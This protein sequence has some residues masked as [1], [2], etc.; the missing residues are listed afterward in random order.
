M[1]QD[2]MVV[3]I[4]VNGKVLR[5]N[6]EDI[7]LPFG[8]EY[9]M[10]LKNL[11]SRKAQVKIT[12]DG[13]D[14]LK[15]KSLLIKPNDTVDLE[16]FLTEDNIA[17]N[18][19][20]FIEKIKEISEF[21]GDRIEDGLIQ[22]E[23][24]YEKA[25]P[26]VQDVHWNNNWNYG[27]MLN[28]NYMYTNCRSDI[29]TNSGIPKGI[30]RGVTLD[31]M[32]SCSLSNSISTQ[33]LQGITVKGSEINQ[34]FTQGNIAQLEDVS[35]V[36]IFRL[37]GYKDNAEKVELPK[38]TKDKLQCKTCGHTCN[39]NAKFCDRCGTYLENLSEISLLEFINEISKAWKTMGSDGRKALCT[40]VAGAKPENNGTLQA[41]LKSLN[42]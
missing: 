41:I 17:K 6:R 22:V 4:K 15:G 7:E 14:V 5:E 27:T 31:S 16:G 36:M 19:F 34:E 9:S 39:S 26:I 28:S 24:T 40:F 18:K 1:Y 33:S 8:S 29:S 11:E 21:R 12:I 2:K 38:F 20:K 42:S 32:D 3:C 35:H 23:F 37:L 10:S 25:K 30:L 13:E